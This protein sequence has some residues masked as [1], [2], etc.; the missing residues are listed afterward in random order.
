MKIASVRTFRLSVPLES[1]FHWATGTAKARTTVLVRVTTSTAGLIGW[2]ESLSWQAAR[3]I[4]DT[5]G[6]MLVGVDLVKWE[7]QR[8]RLLAKVESAPEARSEVIAATGALDVAIWDIMGKVADQPVHKLLGGKLRSQVP[9]YASGLYYSC[10]SPREHLADEAGGY[11]GRGFKAIKMK[12]GRL[13]VKQDVQRI[14]EV[15]EAIAGHAQLMVDSNQA[16]NLARAAEMSGHLENLHISWFEEPMPLT[17]FDFYRSLRETCRVPIGA[18]ENF[19]GSG[20]FEPFVSGQLLDIAQPNVSTAGGINSTLA[21]S[22]MCRLH[23]IRIAF[24]GWGTPVLL[25]ATV[26]LASCLESCGTLDSHDGIRLE[27]PI[28]EW[29]CTPNPLG[30]LFPNALA[31]AKGR[32]EVPD[33]PGL[34]VEINERWLAPYEV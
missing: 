4:D 32:V 34:G 33:R 29:D 28:I 13:E 25:A 10:G 20:E 14:S 24:H 23:G 22:K 9:V 21:I 30:A 3:L 18:G 8:C 15:C 2:G 12:I 7:D 5:I 19:H 11:I 27:F 16:Y 17:K 1:P 31:T 26:H 6:P